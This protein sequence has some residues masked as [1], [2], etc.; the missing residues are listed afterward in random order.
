MDA[1]GYAYVAGST[2]SSLYG[3]SQ[4]TDYFPA[5]FGHAYPSAIPTSNPSLT[6]TLI[7]TAVPSTSVP[8]LNNLSH[9]TILPTS[10]PT[11]NTTVALDP[12]TSSDN[13]AHSTS[14]VLSVNWS[15]SLKDVFVVLLVLAGW[16]ALASSVYCLWTK[17][18]EVV[19]LTKFQYFLCFVAGMVNN[20]LTLISA[21]VYLQDKA[22]FIHAVLLLT[23]IAVVAVMAVT[24]WF[25]VFTNIN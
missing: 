5:K 14:F 23:W 3:T 18:L 9:S 21:H 1:S 22:N 15:V 13:D 7:P 6:P 20:M 4:Y 11:P 19:Q 25:R 8:T 10:I 16:V 24:I 17:D 12:D 2:D